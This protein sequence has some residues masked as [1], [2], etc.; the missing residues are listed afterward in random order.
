MNAQGVGCLLYE[1]FLLSLLS[2]PEDGY[3]MLLLN[4]L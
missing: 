4:I 2:N 1:G 3:G